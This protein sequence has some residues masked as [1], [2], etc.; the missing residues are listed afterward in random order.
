MQRT[1]LAD[2]PGIRGVTVTIDDLAFGE[3]ITA[4]K[5]RHEAQV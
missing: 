5:N 3:T 1:G 4:A 2:Q